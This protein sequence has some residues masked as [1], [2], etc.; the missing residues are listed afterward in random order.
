[1]SDRRKVPQESPFSEAERGEVVTE[2]AL[3]LCVG[4]HGLFGSVSEK[5]RHR[6]DHS[7]HTRTEAE[8]QEDALLTPGC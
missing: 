3:V 7:S 6:Q 4:I 5:R 1:M 8:R 2:R